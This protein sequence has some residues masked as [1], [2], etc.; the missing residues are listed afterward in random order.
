MNTQA[1]RRTQAQRRHEAELQ[2]VQDLLHGELG[3][4]PVYNILHALRAHLQARPDIPPR[5]LLSWADS[6]SRHAWAQ[7]PPEYPSQSN[8]EP[9]HGT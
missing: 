1:N 2:Q 9:D 4:V 7:I 3:N 5:E 6:L 8:E